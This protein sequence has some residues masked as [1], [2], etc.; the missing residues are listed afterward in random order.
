MTWNHR[1]VRE[2]LSSGEAWYSIREAFYNDA[3]KI[4]AYTEEPVDICG[5]SIEDMRKYLQ[6]CMDC[7][8]YPIL[9]DGKVEFAKENE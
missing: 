8:D 6:W 1:V 9:E 4:Y 3:G 2:I 5:S 7:L